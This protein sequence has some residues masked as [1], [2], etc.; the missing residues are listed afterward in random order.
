MPAKTAKSG[1]YAQAT[2]FSGFCKPVQD[3]ISKWIEQHGN[4]F[5]NF[6]KLNNCFQL[7]DIVRTRRAQFPS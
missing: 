1:G 2:I 3:V 5:S 4:D 6:G 7:N